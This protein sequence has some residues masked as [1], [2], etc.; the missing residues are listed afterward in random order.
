MA[1]RIVSI[2]WQEPSFHAFSATPSVRKKKQNGEDRDRERGREK[3]REWKANETAG[4]VDCNLTD[5]ADNDFVE[6][7]G[8][9]NVNQRRDA[10]EAAK[11][12]L[13]ARH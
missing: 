3:E 5:T 6:Q 7:M 13:I 2:P 1:S 4:D 10:I 11:D 12:F 8:L 9:E